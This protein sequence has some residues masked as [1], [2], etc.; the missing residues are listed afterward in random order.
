MK[1]Y[2][3]SQFAV[4]KDIP[5]EFDQF[6]GKDVW[7]KCRITYRNDYFLYLRF[8]SKEVLNFGGSDDRDLVSITVNS[9]SPEDVDK[10]RRG[11]IPAD[12]IRQLITKSSAWYASNLALVEPLD[13][14]PSS[15]IIED[16]SKYETTENILYKYA[17][18][19]VWIRADRTYRTGGFP[20]YIKILEID[21]YYCK[22]LPI[23]A[24]YVD[25]HWELD[26]DEDVYSL[27]HPWRTSRSHIDDIVLSKPIEIL[28]TEE[29]QYELEQCPEYYED[30]DEEYNEDDE[31]DEGDDE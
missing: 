31:Y 20:E 23:R 10:L 26:P 22:Y 17:G 8:L 21:G 11:E 13:I 19:D 18:K 3:K 25:E 27:M 24:G 2:A 30:E 29:I 7:V 1:I 5:T 16:M 28:T 12:Q 15:S 4:D 6:I 14:I 9:L